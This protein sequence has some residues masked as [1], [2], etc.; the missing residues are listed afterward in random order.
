MEGRIVGHVHGVERYPHQLALDDG[1][2]GEGAVEV[3]GVERV[4]PIPESDVRRRGLLGLQRD[5]PVHGIDHAQLLAAKQQL[6]AKG[7]PVELPGREP[8]LAQSRW[9][10]VATSASFPAES[11]RV[12]HAGANS[13]RT[14]WP[15]AASAAATRA[16]ACSYGTQIATWIAPPP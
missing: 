3:D 14:R 7:G 16:S 9:L 15:P 5:D 4:E 6:P 11:A 13:S 8:H 10:V 1:V 2:L 12:H